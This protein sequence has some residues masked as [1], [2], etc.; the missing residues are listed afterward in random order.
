MSSTF[1]QVGMIRPSM[2]VTAMV[3]SSYSGS[4]RLH[5]VADLVIRLA[6]R[7]AM[8]GADR[9]RAEDRSRTWGS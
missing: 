8:E 9:R 5:A 4:V 2:G 3:C 6:V 7:Q 1:V